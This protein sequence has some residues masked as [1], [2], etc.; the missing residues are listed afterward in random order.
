MY[1]APVAEVV[2]DD[3]V[4]R[5]PTV[6][7]ASDD[8]ALARRIGRLLNAEQIRVAAKTDRLEHIS[9][10]AGDGS[11]TVAILCYRSNDNEALIRAIRDDASRVRFVVVVGQDPDRRAVMQALRARADALVYLDQLETALGPSVRAVI[12]DQ[13]VFPRRDR[14]R[15]DVPALSHREREVL[16][17]AVSGHTNDEIANRMYLATSTVKSHLTSAFSKLGV[18]SRS[19]AA[20]LVLDPTEPIARVIFASPDGGAFQ[21]APGEAGASANRPAPANHSTD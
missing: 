8:R 13:V 15:V 1:Q 4:I 11:E 19:E 12:A 2:E 7:V 3:A 10:L 18:K 16:R 14:R 9:T 20:A 5:E 21:L 17:L 6:V